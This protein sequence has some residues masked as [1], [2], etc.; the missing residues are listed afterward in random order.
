MAEIHA[1]AFL[2]AFNAASSPFRIFPGIFGAEGFEIKRTGNIFAMADF[3][4]E[5]NRQYS[6]DDYKSVLSLKAGP[7]LGG[8]LS[9]A[10]AALSGS[11]EPV[12]LHLDNAPKKNPIPAPQSNP[13]QDATKQEVPSTEDKKAAEIKAYHALG[14]KGLAIGGLDVVTRKIDFH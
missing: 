7:I 9:L 11:V 13:P 6:S 3:A 10:T 4:A 2:V 12:A 1:I 14:P 8:L 5:V